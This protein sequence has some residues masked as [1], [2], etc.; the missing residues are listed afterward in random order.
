LQVSS[1]ATI[2]N[3]EGEG[4]ILDIVLGIVGAIRGGYL[5]STIR[6]PGVE[7]GQSL[8]HVR[9]GSRSHASFW[10][11]ITRSPAAHHLAGAAFQ[12]GRRPVIACPG[13]ASEM[14][15][16]CSRDGRRSMMAPGLSRMQPGLSV[17]ATEPRNKTGSSELFVASNF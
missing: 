9:G 2:V 13:A 1:P 12:A 14:A 11:I 4:L 16:A 17:S 10:V 3:K 8:Q 7:R 15:R 6:R 5:F